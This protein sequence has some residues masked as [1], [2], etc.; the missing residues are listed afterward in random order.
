MCFHSFIA[1]HTHTHP[2][3]PK[4]GGI[5]GC[6]LLGIIA[7]AYLADLKLLIDEASELVGVI[8]NIIGAL[9]QIGLQVLITFLSS[10]FGVMV[11]DLDADLGTDLSKP[12]YGLDDEVET[13]KVQGTFLCV[14]GCYR[15]DSLTHSVGPPTLTQD[16][17]T[18]YKELSEVDI[19]AINSELQTGKE[20]LDTLYPGWVNSTQ[21]ETLEDLGEIWDAAVGNKTAS[22]WCVEGL[23][24]GNIHSANR[25]LVRPSSP[26]QAQPYSHTPHQV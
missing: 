3:S 4:G 5:Y 6:V 12:N 19:A 26:L 17:Y 16:F 9:V 13:F 25:R 2:L 24:D 1:H 20:I 18:A 23:R 8:D 15:S 22:V 21:A 11:K 14:W 7:K 10:Q